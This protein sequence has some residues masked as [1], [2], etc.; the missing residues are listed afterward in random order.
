ML[1]QKYINVKPLQ[2]H[3]REKNLPFTQIQAFQTKIIVS[4]PPYLSFPPSC[5]KEEIFVYTVRTCLTIQ[6]HISTTCPV[7]VCPSLTGG[8][9]Y[10]NT[11]GG[12]RGGGRLLCH[13][14]MFVR[15]G[16]GEQWWIL[17]MSSQYWQNI[18]TWECGRHLFFLFTLTF[19]AEIRKA[20][21]KIM[22]KPV[23]TFFYYWGYWWTDGFQQMGDYFVNTE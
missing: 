1:G 18:L 12:R 3:C 5:L 11:V 10:I 16:G 9:G 7:P 21:T 8:A 15:W 17:S 2:W 4:A 22:I 14:L 6:F 20:L 19:L 23:C 13:L